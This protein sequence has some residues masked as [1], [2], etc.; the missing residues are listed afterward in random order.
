MGMPGSMLFALGPMSI[1]RQSIA[2]RAARLTRASRK[3]PSA[4]SRFPTSHAIARCNA[5]SLQLALAWSVVEPA[6]LTAGPLPNADR[7][8]KRVSITVKDTGCTYCT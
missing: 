2:C 5:P 7:T 4:G 8:S 3:D 1:A 6:A